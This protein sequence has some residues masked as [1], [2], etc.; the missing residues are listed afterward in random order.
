MH[1]ALQIQAH[2]GAF[3]RWLVLGQHAGIWRRTCGLAGASCLCQKECCCGFLCMLCRMC[4][5]IGMNLTSFSQRDGAKSVPLIPPQMSCLLC[6][7][8]LSLSRR[9][10]ICFFPCLPI[11]AL[12][13]SAS[14]ILPSLAL[15]PFGPHVECP[16]VSPDLCPSLVCL[17]MRL[18]CHI[19]CC[20][21]CCKVLPMQRSFTT[22][23]KAIVCIHLPVTMI[24]L[25]TAGIEC[26]SSITLS[27]PSEVL[28]LV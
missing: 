22:T 13:S 16:S 3:P 12:R 18:C 20:C 8:M 4:L 9:C 27:L 28:M 11:H 1:F 17:P 5:P 7:L 25:L 10:D 2:P 15:V 24:T 21:A 26:C 19:G 14:R 23:L 6:P